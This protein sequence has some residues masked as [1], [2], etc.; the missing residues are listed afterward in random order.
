[1]AL[2]E[3]VVPSLSYFR[4]VGIKGG[5]AYLLL[6]WFLGQK[7]K[8]DKLHIWPTSGDFLVGVVRFLQEFHSSYIEQAN[9]FRTDL[10]S[11]DSDRLHKIYLLLAE[12]GAGGILCG[13]LADKLNVSESYVT[14]AV[15]CRP[16]LIVQD[17]V[18]KKWRLAFPHLQPIV[19][20][21]D[22]L[23]RNHPKQFAEQLG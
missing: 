5:L 11:D 23:Q 17:A 20:A 8:V 16:E 12:A 14:K 7:N 9:R 6:R 3:A 4:I 18:S 22:Y 13:D 21:Y 2:L 1:M 10:S 19:R 15:E